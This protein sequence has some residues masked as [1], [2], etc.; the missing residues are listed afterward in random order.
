ML[1]SFTRRKPLSAFDLGFSSQLVTGAVTGTTFDATNYQALTLYFKFT[2]VAGTGNL[3]FTVEAYDDA[4]AD[5]F[6]LQAIE[7]ATG[8]STLTLS[9][10]RRASGNV[11]VN[12]ECRLTELQFHKLRIKSSLVTSASTDTITITGELLGN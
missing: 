10:I 2:R 1:A 5:W 6:P 8:T 9:T 3:D 4:Q 11:S 12:F 7:T